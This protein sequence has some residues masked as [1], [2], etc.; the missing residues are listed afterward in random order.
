V[1]VRDT[2]GHTQ[3]S[4]TADIYGHMLPESQRQAVDRIG[5]LLGGDID[6]DVPPAERDDD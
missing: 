1:V 6:A 2:L 3:I 4:T 5:A